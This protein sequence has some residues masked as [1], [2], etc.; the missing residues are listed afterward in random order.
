MGKSLNHQESHICLENHTHSP[1][2][3]WGMLHFHHNRWHSVK[4]KLPRKR[5]GSSKH[6]SVFTDQEST[7]S[8]PESA[9][10][11][12]NIDSTLENSAVDT[13]SIVSGSTHK[14]SMKSRIKALIAEEMSKRRGRHHRSSSYPTR[15]QFDTTNSVHRSDTESPTETKSNDDVLG[16]HRRLHS[17][18][19]LDPVLPN[20]SSC[21][22][23]AAM[24]NVNY[25]T[26]SEVSKLGRQPVRDHTVLQDKLIYAIEPSKCASLQESKL[27][28]DALDLL[29]MRKELFLKILQDPSSSLAHQLHCRRTPNMRFGLTKSV[30]FP[31]SGSSVKRDFKLENSI[32]KQENGCSTKDENEVQGCVEMTEGLK[33]LEFSDKM[34]RKRHDSKVA[35]KHFKN[36]RDKIKHVIRDRKKEKNRIIMDAVHHKIP[37]GQSVQETK[38]DKFGKSSLQR[39]KR[40]SSYNESFDRYKRLLEIT[41]NREE[42]DHSSERLRFKT[43][44]TTSS[45]SK[46][47]A[48]GRMFSLPDLRSYS[49]IHIDDSCSTSVLKTPEGLTEEKRLSQEKL[50]EVGE[51]YEDFGD[52]KTAESGSSHDLNVENEQISDP[53]TLKSDD[54][55]EDEEISQE[56]E[57]SVPED[58]KLARSLISSTDDDF[59]FLQH[60]LASENT[61][62]I[63]T[64]EIQAKQFHIDT[65][66]KTEF[67]YVK[68]VLELSGFSR[69]EILGEWHSAERPLNPLVF[70]E[71]EGC[72]VSQPECS[73]NEEGGSCDHLLLFDLINE[74]LLDIYEKSFCYW[75]MPLTNRSHM[76]QMPRGHHVLETVWAEISRFLSFRP[77]T[78]Q[79]IDDAVKQDLGKNDGWMNLQLDGE[80]VGL[81]VEDLIFDDLLEEIISSCH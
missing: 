47:P 73:G 78:D 11:H 65:K 19:L 9:E 64:R 76:H 5:H 25:L 17:T 14:S 69:D 40:T 63:D 52:S 50:L 49:C 54:V 66:N 42:K 13:K 34:L 57:V 51:V 28:M 70:E 31:A 1:R 37:Y 7:R 61:I 33:E 77:E 4:K 81:E 32:N 23:C 39:F 75:P 43:G 44:D 21:K 56:P 6:S 27:F 8:T 35:L 38:D 18:A 58:S 20:E 12:E 68:D 36:L 72:L 67:N 80:C 71:V 59:S 53:Q 62:N 10:M 79:G 46:N 16:S 48:L 41:A 29:N 3:M 26:Q 30:S 22:L 45:V 55:S 15:T 2:C 24:L 74:V 60:D